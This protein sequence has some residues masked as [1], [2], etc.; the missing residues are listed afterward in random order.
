MEKMVKHEAE[1]SE[2]SALAEAL[3]GLLASGVPWC[4]GVGGG[5]SGG[6]AWDEW[7]KDALRRTL[8]AVPL[9]NSSVFML[10]VRCFG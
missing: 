7:V 5:E 3:G 4:Q 8:G 1:K 2:Q 6:T 9:E 10:A